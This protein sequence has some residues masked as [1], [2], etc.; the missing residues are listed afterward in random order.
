MPPV[1]VS[2]LVEVMA[3]AEPSFSVPALIVQLVSVV[4]VP[5]RVQVLLP[6]FWKAAKLRYCAAAPTA[7]G[8]C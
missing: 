6:C 8:R 2:A 5:P 4:A 3:P 7:R 1:R